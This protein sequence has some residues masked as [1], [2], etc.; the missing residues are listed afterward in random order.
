MLPHTTNSMKYTLHDTEKIRIKK[1]KSTNTTYERLPFQPNHRSYPRTQRY[2]DFRSAPQY[3][4]GTI[5]LETNEVQQ[6]Q[7][8]EPQLWKMIG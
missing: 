6:G 8:G 1:K 5:L 2:G 3:F 7:H 4:H